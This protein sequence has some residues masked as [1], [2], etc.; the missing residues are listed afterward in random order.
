M[1][2]RTI[3]ITGASRGIGAA[4]ACAAAELGANVVINARSEAELASVARRIT[5][6]G[7]QAL[8]VPGDVSHREDCLRLVKSAVERFGGLDVLVNN[9]A[10]IGPLS[11]ILTG[12]PEDAQRALAVNVLGPLMLAQAA[13]VHLRPR[14]GRIINVTSGAAGMPASG[15][16]NYCASKA[17]LNAYNHILAKEEPELTV[18]AFEHARQQGEGHPRG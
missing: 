6:A 4:T 10:I 7:G 16:A 15:L 1:T 14:Q 9:A 13:A 12:A 8:S 11:P 5:D 17:A 18:I 3:L 2:S